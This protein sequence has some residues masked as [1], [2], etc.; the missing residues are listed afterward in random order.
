MLE[1]PGKSEHLSLLPVLPLLA[2][3]IEHLFDTVWVVTLLCLF[4]SANTNF[5]IG[6]AL[7]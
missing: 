1:F 5:T 2:H 7:T 4:Y 6:N 3:F